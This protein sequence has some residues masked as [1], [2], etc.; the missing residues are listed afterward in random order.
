MRTG[1]AKAGW[2]VLIVLNTGMLLNHLVAIFLVAT[3]ADEGRMFIAYAVVNALAL[4]VLFFAYRVRQRWAWASIWLVVLATAVTIAYG[5]D[6]IGLIY[7]AV[8]GVMA[9]AQLATA[10]E[11]FSAVQ[12]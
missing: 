2:I 10:R 5:V 11:F 4:L 12:A 7:V 3:S 1:L 8:A 9:L 6:T